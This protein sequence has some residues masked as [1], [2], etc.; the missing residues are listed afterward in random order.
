[1]LLFLDADTTPG[2]ELFARSV[3]AIR[4]RDLQFLSVFGR[5]EMRTF[6]ERVV[7]PHFFAM[8]AMRFGGTGEINASPNVA[9]KIANGQCI[10][11]TRAG[12]EKVGGHASVRMKPAEDI[13]LAQRSFALGLRTEMIIGLDYLSTRMYR[14]LKEI[15]DGWSKNVWTASPDAIPRGRFWRA[16]LGPALLVPPVMVL[17]PPLV[18]LVSPVLPVSLNLLAWAM[19]TSGIML[20][21]WALVY[22][23]LAGYTPIYAFSYPLGAGA[24]LYIIVRAIVRGRRVM[25]KGR[26]YLT[27]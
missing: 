27:G 13:A 17:A 10:F 5:Q 23:A 1:V 14:S 7:Q 21:F 22:G 6:W 20:M 11:M 19:L 16:L 26:E 9:D 18:L 4:A 24:V 12:Y 25:W 8:I 15:I 2:A 3:N